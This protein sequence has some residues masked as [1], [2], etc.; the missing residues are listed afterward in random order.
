[1]RIPAIS[2]MTVM[3]CSGKGLD[4]FKKEAALKTASASVCLIPLEGGNTATV[5]WQADTGLIPA[6]TMKAITTATALQV[7]GPDFVFETKVYH[8]KGDLV[9]KGGGDPTFAMSSLTGD[10][11]PW[12]AALKEAEIAEITG[13]IIIDPTCFESQRA[14]NDWPWGDVGNYFGAGPSGMNFYENTI[15]LTFKPGQVGTD[16]KLIKVWPK[17]PGV[18]FEN[19]MKTGRSNSGDQGY[20]YAGPE[21][22]MIALRGSVPAGGDYT[23]RGALPNPAL[24]CGTALKDFLKAEGILVKGKVKVMAK[25]VSAGKP[26]TT[27]QS[28]PLSKIIT[29]TNHRSVNLFADSIFKKLTYSGTT[30]K[31]VSKVNALWKKKGV[32]LT[33]FVMLDGSGLSPRNTVTARQL[34]MILK[35]ARKHETGDVFYKSLPAAGSS[36]TMSSWG[37]GTSMV[38]RVRAKT[39]GMTR[40]RTV[41]GYLKGKSGR[42]FAFAIMTNNT[43]YYPKPAMVRLLTALV[44]EN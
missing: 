42:E 28:P 7:L 22:K 32:N 9:V 1:M 43:I 26:L 16:A 4:V 3:L 30:E 31:A 27:T 41:A 23:I 39:G 44:N 37:K 25:K 13:D 12:V 6:S 17:P 15:S 19:F 35:S 18:T 34:A 11:K 29:G 10:F 14:P 8:H 24:M 20:V 5:S 38:G 36:G 40:V 2:V 21:A 33:G